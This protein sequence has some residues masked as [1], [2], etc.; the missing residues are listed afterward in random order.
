MN[1]LEVK[2]EKAILAD[3]NSAA[4]RHLISFAQFEKREKHQW[5]SV[6]FRIY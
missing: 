1:S 5:S 3:L 2:Y 6:T 4:L